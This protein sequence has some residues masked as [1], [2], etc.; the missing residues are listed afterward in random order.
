MECI[1]R[2]DYAAEIPLPYTGVSL[3]KRIYSFPRAEVFAYSRV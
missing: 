1:S 2:G 3:A